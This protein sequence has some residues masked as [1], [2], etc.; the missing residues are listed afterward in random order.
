M[1]SEWEQ[2]RR[3]ENCSFNATQRRTARSHAHASV[4]LRGHTR[5]SPTLTAHQLQLSWHS[6][7]KP[8]GYAAL[9]SIIDNCRRWDVKRVHRPC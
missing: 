2:A 7:T 3:D 9:H 1:A 6:L 4:G 8:D 5:T